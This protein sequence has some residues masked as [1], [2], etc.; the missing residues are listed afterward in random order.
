MNWVPKLQKYNLATDLDVNDRDRLEGEAS[1]WFTCA[2][3]EN[4]QIPPQEASTGTLGD[5][6]FEVDS[7]A[8]RFG[9]EFSRIVKERN[10]EKALVLAKHI[11]YRLSPKKIEKIRKEYVRRQHELRRD[12]MAITPYEER[13]LPGWINWVDS[14]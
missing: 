10:Q 9:A 13:K 1:S 8:H 2:V 5:A 12:I 11:N 14:P 3:G 7:G 6:I 4:L